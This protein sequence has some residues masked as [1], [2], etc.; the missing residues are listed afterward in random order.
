MLS[1]HSIMSIDSRIAELRKSDTGWGWSVCAMVPVLGLATTG[2]HALTRRT[3]K[4]ILWSV[5]APFIAGLSIGI[6]DVGINNG[7]IQNDKNAENAMLIIGTLATP[8]L[9]KL[10]QEESRQ[11]VL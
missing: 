7:Q 11:A 9:F 3:W 4:P 6:A 10:G 1:F 5:V 8:F 2:Y